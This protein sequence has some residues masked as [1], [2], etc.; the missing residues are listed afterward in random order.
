MP[1]FAQYI[2]APANF[3]GSSAPYFNPNDAWIDDYTEFLF[4]ARRSACWPSQAAPV[5]NDIV[6][7]LVTGKANMICRVS[8]GGMLFREGGFDLTGVATNDIL[9]LNTTDFQLYSLG[10]PDFVSFV[11]VKRET[12]FSTTNY[13][14]I[15]G[16]GSN[17]AAGNSE[18]QIAMGIGGVVTVTSASNGSVVTYANSASSGVISA[19]LN[20]TIQL[21]VAVE[22]GRVKNYLNGVLI[23]TSSVDFVKPFNNLTGQA[24]RLGSGVGGPQFKGIIK[25]WGMTRLG[26][27]KTAAERVAEDWEANHVGLNVV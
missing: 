19:L 15:I 9:T 8:G 23:A 21:A 11:W 14:N 20:T 6:N 1:Q 26:N 24:L 10:N 17:T 18:Y 16:R 25:R 2:K 27:G 5:H 22:G 13:Q 12:G 7:N 4:D 3:I